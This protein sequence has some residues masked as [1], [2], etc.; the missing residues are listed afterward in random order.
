MESNPAAASF[1]RQHSIIGLADLVETT[2]PSSDTKLQFPQDMLSQLLES[3]AFAGTICI[4]AVTNPVAYRAKIVALLQELW[5]VDE[6][7]A[8][9]QAVLSRKPNRRVDIT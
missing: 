4:V 9:I 8:L 3:G 5:E 1:H 7:Q 2:V 6:G